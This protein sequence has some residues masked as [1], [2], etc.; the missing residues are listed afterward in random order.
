MHTNQ[1]SLFSIKSNAYK[2]ISLFSINQM[3]TNQT[4]LFP[5]NQTLLTM[6]NTSI[7]M[8]QD[9][10][11]FRLAMANGRFVSEED[12]L[13]C[14]K[15]EFMAFT[16][17]NSRQPLAITDGRETNNKATDDAQSD[18]TLEEEE[19]LEDT[20]SS[21][22]FD[23]GG[24][25]GGGGD[26]YIK[27]SVGDS[28]DFSK[29]VTQPQPK[30]T[31]PI[32]NNDTIPT[33]DFNTNTNT[34]TDLLL[35]TFYSNNKNINRNI[36]RIINSQL[37]INTT[38]LNQNNGISSGDNDNYNIWYMVSSDFERSDNLKRN[39]TTFTAGGNIIL[40]KSTILGLALSFEKDNLLLDNRNIKANNILTGAYFRYNITNRIFINSI[41]SYLYSNY[42]NNVKY[43]SNQISTSTNLGIQY[44]YIVATTGLNIATLKIN[45]DENKKRYTYSN[46][47]FGLIYKDFL[48][49][50]TKDKFIQ[51]KPQIFSEVTFILKESQIND[52]DIFKIKDNNY[53]QYG[54]KCNVD[55][56]EK[57]KIVLEFSQIR[58]KVQTNRFGV[59]VGCQF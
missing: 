15:H 25:D 22:T 13:E 28:G 50:S 36:N 5:T 8:I 9:T 49:I 34:N 54:I 1:T 52:K 17:V 33:T 37:I 3:Y 24:N 44:K 11:P 48:N 16:L 30:D 26:N 41:L 23:G 12:L 38:L 6:N 29:T 27:D 2:S 40:N 58:E 4:L 51:I 47:T 35:K 57:I 53:I 14:L 10:L 56:R 59:S 55:I 39:N 42:S 20:K 19:Q 46:I 31:K 18:K 7:E 21:K 45:P 43:T 32:V